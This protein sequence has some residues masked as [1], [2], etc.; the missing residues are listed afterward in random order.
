MVC[1]MDKQASII[2]LL[3]LK[4]NWLEIAQLALEIKKSKLYNRTSS[5]E[6]QTWEEYCKQSLGQSKQ[7]VD[8]SIRAAEVMRILKTK[9]KVL[10][11]PETIAQAITL[12][13]LTP[14]NMEK[15]AE[16]AFKVAESENRRVTAE[17]FKKLTGDF[18]ENG[19]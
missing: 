8:R 19:L 15:V 2:N 5:G 13:G 3:Q 9:T 14:T 16:A 18:L 4:D 12:F 7:Y 1:K 10:S 6:K 17:D 11:F